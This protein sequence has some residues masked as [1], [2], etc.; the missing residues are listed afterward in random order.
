MYSGERNKYRSPNLPPKFPVMVMASNAQ[1][2][3]SKRLLRR[4]NMSN[5]K[6]KE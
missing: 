2:N 1:V 5:W 4:C 3:I 6:G